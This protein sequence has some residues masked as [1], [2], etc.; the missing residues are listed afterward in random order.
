MT[1]KKYSLGIVGRKAGMT[2]VFT[3]DGK[4]IPVTLIEATPNRIT[5]IKTSETDGYSAV[6]VAVGSRRAALI[7]KPVAGHLAK[8]K[9]EAG[10]GLWELRV[11]AD[12]IGDFSVGGEI[13]ADIFEVGQ[14]VD[15]QGVTKGKGFQG[16]IKRWNFRMGDATH[17]NSLSHRAPGSLGQRQTPGRVFPGKKM[18]G[19][20]GAVQ[21]S[22]QN[23]EV[24]RVDAE[25]GLIA[26]RGAVPGAPGGDVI[27]RPASKA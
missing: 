26:V 6:Q 27:V 11:E 1:A 16:T 22:T 7:T 15:V 17:G 3:E 25:R 12:K 18:S 23:L 4:S 24:V 14:K 9:V 13:K 21:Q 5:Q 20:M 10:R 2:R 8:A 19:H